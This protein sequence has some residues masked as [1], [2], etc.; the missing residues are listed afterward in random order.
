MIGAVENGPLSAEAI[1]AQKKITLQYFEKPRWFRLYLDKDRFMG[2]VWKTSIFLNRNA[3][4]N[5]KR[6]CLLFSFINVYKRRMKIYLA[7]TMS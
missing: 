1:F 7:V 5:F 2:K 3:P 4:D 6:N